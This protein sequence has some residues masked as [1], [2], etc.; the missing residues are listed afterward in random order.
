MNLMK[1]PALFMVNNVELMDFYHILKSTIHS[2]KLWCASRVE[3]FFSAYATAAYRSGDDG[4]LGSS[5][6]KLCS[7]PLFR[8]SIKDIAALFIFFVRAFHYYNLMKHLVFSHHFH[9]LTKTA[10]PK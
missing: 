8:P 4:S 10:K 9:L 7:H 6:E 5:K 3:V 1:V 2:C